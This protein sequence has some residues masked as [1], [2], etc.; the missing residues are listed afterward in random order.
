[1]KGILILSSLALQP[2]KATKM[3]NK[4]IMKKIMKEKMSKIKKKIKKIM[5]PSAYEICK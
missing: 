2:N 3:R 5:V 1:M 4:K